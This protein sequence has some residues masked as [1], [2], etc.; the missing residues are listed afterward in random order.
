MDNFRSTERGMCMGLVK[1]IRVKHTFR[2]SGELRYWPSAQVKKRVPAGALRVAACASAGR[3][4]ML[5]LSYFLSRHER[6]ALTTAA[7][8][9]S[10]KYFV[11]S[12]PAI[13]THTGSMYYICCGA[14]LICLTRMSLGRLYLHSVKHV[15]SGRER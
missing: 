15:C 9:R 13:C 2:L 1:M 6:G 8:N 7:C 4:W 12:G 3:L 5:S 10:K 14:Y 11:V